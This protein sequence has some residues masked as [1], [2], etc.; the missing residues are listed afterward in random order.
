[1]TTRK[2]KA[3]QAPA[4]VA[5]PA[6]AAPAAPAAD[7]PAVN[8]E[9]L[10]LLLKNGVD[11]AAALIAAGLVAAP[12]AA[13]AKQLEAAKAS[14]T[15]KDEPKPLNFILHPTGGMRPSSTGKTVLIP[16]GGKTSDGRKCGGTLW[17]KD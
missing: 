3:A 13:P 14:E 10:A 7:K 2:V 6:Q 11:P 16:V 8:A 17:I 4:T 1:M 9:V 5:A 12:Q 15:P